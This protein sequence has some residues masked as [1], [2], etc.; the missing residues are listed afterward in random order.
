MKNKNVF[1]ILV[2][3]I[4]IIIIA[5]IK[6]T[7]SI[8]STISKAFQKKL[9][10][11]ITFKLTVVYVLIFSII[12]FITNTTILFI[13]R[14]YIIRESSNNLINTKNLLS[15]YLS[16]DYELFREKA[17]ET[18]KNQN[19]QI[20]LFDESRE[21][22]YSTSKNP[23]D[24][25]F[26]NADAPKTINIDSSEFLVINSKIQSNTQ[27][28]Y[29]QILKELSKE[30]AYLATA[31]MILLVLTLLAILVTI[32]IGSKTS[33]KMLI[34]VD[35]MTK[36]VK[37]ITIKNLD[38][39][40]DVSGSKDEL[41]DLA[42]TFNEMFDRLQKSYEQQ[43]QFVSDASHELRTP[44]SVIQGY[45]N[46]LNRWG[47]DDREV[48]EESITAIASEAE[49][50]KDLVEKLLFLA[51]SDKDTQK[52]EKTSF[53][54]SELIEEIVKETR[55]I[56]SK[57]VILNDINKKQTIFA[58]KKLLKQSIRIF[59]D[60]AVKYTQ[61]GG[62]ITLN[63]Y[64]K[65]G[66]HIIEIKD[67]GKGIPKDDLPYIFNRFY[68]ADKARTK[69][70]GGTGLGLSIAK[71]IISKHKGVINVKSAINIGTTFT[72]YIPSD[73]YK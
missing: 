30:H 19:M 4:F 11:S 41:K 66:F 44:I 2:K 15:Y 9:R 48:L 49:N 72:I 17:I 65:K 21:I 61:E 12:L 20:S 40:L 60:N 28:I 8:L 5:I 37:N 36:T 46:L 18:S 51:R 31:F 70:T 13:L 10:V 45:A 7:L 29:I 54:L 59:M 25:F 62:A 47:K 52:V 53:E 58:D 68:R 63:S 26:K 57:H 69:E 55:L 1:V 32:V 67:T 33:K 16:E 38:T 42:L 56:D 6:L 73:N 34:P 50:M 14:Y 71:W 27:T 24:D 3:Q 43:N 39:R 23:N 64:F 22:T 35:T